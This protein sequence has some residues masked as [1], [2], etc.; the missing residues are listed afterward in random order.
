MQHMT[1]RDTARLSNVELKQPWGTH[2]NNYQNQDGFYLEILPIFRHQL[3]FTV[4]AIP[5]GKA[6]VL[7]SKVECI[8]SSG[9][10]ALNIDTV[11]SLYPND[12]MI[13]MLLKPFILPGVLDRTHIT[14]I[15]HKRPPSTWINGLPV[16]VLACVQLQPS[17]HQAYMHTWLWV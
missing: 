4:S 17:D 13:Q 12:W 16:K 2:P 1:L 10:K 14:L 6:V 15:S 8:Y 7:M 11:K 3:K 5:S 9:H